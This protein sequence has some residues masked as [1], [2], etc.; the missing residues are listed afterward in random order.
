MMF[1]AAQMIGQRLATRF[2]L[3]RCIGRCGALAASLL[4]LRQQARLVL[5]QR[6]L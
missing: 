1:N 6:L 5:G 2:A 3:G 4:Q